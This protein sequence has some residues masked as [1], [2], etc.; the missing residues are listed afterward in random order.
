M[1][2]AEYAPILAWAYF[3]IPLA[4]YEFFGLKMGYKWTLTAG[5]RL[6]MAKWKPLRYILGAFIAWLFWHFVIEG[7]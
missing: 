6:L 1:I 4:L 2:T 7:F 3:L 5:M